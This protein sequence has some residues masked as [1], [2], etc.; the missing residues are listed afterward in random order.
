M[1][2]HEFVAKLINW[3]RDDTV[4]FL[5]ISTFDNNF[6]KTLQAK[7]VRCVCF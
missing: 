7:E 6:R 5:T 2:K 1:G 4:T 3:E